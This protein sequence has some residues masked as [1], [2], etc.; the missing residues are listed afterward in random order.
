[1]FFWGGQLLFNHFG[2]AS[3]KAK[4]GFIC[5]VNVGQY[6]N[7]DGFGFKSGE[8]GDLSILEPEISKWSC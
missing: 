2:S 4:L 5:R 7:M 3:L 8:V 1:M 6:V